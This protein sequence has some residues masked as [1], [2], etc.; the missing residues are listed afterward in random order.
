MAKLI[1]FKPKPVPK[2]K[3]GIIVQARMTSSRFP[4]KSMAMLHGKPVLEWVLERV[5][6]VRGP[7]SMEPIRVVLAVP[8]DPASEPM[9]EL[10]D[11]MLVGNFLGSE[12]NVLERYYQCAMFFNF[13]YIMRI[14]ADCPF[15]DPVVCSEVYQLLCWRKLDYTS[16]IYP[17]RTYAKGLDCEAFT[18]D[19]LEAAYKLAE[20]DYDKEH[21]T[22]WMLRSDII[23]KGNIAQQIDNS[24]KNWCVDIPE[25]IARLEEEIKQWD[26]K[27]DSVPIIMPRPKNDNQAD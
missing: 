14:T 6:L 3:P 23:H 27:L 22:P 19:C 15:I 17:K 11:R 5:S 1:G 4:G 13:D 21:V 26:A 12:T 2:K 24:E 8:D 10:A 7:K 16:N 18:M 9:L 25:D 20:S